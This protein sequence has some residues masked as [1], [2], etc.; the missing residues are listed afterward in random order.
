MLLVLHSDSPLG[1][2]LLTLTESLFTAGLPLQFAQCPEYSGGNRRK[3]LGLELW[4]PTPQVFIKNKPRCLQVKQDPHLPLVSCWM[5]RL[6]YCN[7][8]SVVTNTKEM[9]RLQISAAGQCLSW[10]HV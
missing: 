3:M 5:I 1:Q 10:S 4:C 2:E 8:D 9:K 7:G 6:F